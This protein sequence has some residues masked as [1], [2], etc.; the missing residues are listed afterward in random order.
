MVLLNFFFALLAAK[1]IIESEIYTFAWLVAG[2]CFVLNTLS[3][4]QYYF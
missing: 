1:W 3:V 4:L 2:V